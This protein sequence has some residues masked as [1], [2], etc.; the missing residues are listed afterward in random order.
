MNTNPKT[1]AFIFGK[2]DDSW[3]GRLLKFNYNTGIVERIG[4]TLKTKTG[5]DVIGDWR[6]EIIGFAEGE[7]RIFTTTSLSTR[8]FRT[9]MHDPI[10]RTDAS[11]MTMGY[12]QSPN[13]GFYFGEGMH[14][15]P[16]YDVFTAF[17]TDTAF[18]EIPSR[19]DFGS[20]EGSPVKDGYT[21]V[22]AE[23][24]SVLDMITAAGKFKADSFNVQIDDGVLDL[25]FGGSPWRISGIEIKTP[26]WPLSTAPIHGNPEPHIY[27]DQGSRILYIESEEPIDHLRICNIKE[28]VF[29]KKVILSPE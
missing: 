6:E 28:Q 23:D 3:G 16:V 29:L 22:L 4:T 10:Y 21:R 13:P 12:P 24:K 7:V 25:T 1:G 26:D 11:F 20:M 17:G 8:R 19:F 27:I 2:G 5:A 14:S 15:Q 9:F 18:T